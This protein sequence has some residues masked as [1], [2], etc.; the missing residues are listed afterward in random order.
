MP[1]TPPDSDAFF[2]PK[3]HPATAEKKKEKEKRPQNPAP[4]ADKPRGKPRPAG[5]VDDDGSASG[6]GGGGGGLHIHHGVGGQWA[7][8]QEMRIEAGASLFAA[9]R[10][11]R[12]K[13]DSKRRGED[14]ESSE[15]G[16][17]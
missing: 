16:E 3:A 5:A 4:T 13:R 17:G 11:Q 8:A 2:G 12:R 14:T 1:L 10:K 15:E 9:G 7:V 6:G